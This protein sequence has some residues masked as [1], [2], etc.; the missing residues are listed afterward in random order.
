MKFL[1]IPLLILLGILWRFSTYESHLLP[2]LSSGFLTAEALVLDAPDRRQAEQRLRVEWEGRGLLLKI[3]PYLLVRV[4]DR[5]R[6]S[7]QILDIEA[8]EGE[9]FSYRHYLLML[10]IQNAFKVQYLEVEPMTL[11]ELFRT[12]WR[13]FLLR[14]LEDV[15]RGFEAYLKP[16]YVEPEWGLVSGLLL[17]SRAG[18]EPKLAAAFRDAGLMHLIAVSGYNIS[19]V[20]A[21]AISLLGFLSFRKRLVGSAC[22]VTLFVLL[23]GPSAS[24][25]RAALMGC[26]ALFAHFTG[27][28]SVALFSLLWGAL[29]IGL[30][31]PYRLVY[32]IGF[33]LSFLATLS[34]LIFH[35][36]L[37]QFAPRILPV[38]ERWPTFLQ[39]S[40]LLAFAAQVFTFP[41][42]A[43]YFQTFSWVT[44]P[45]NIAVAPFLPVAMALSGASILFPPI[46]LLNIGVLK[47]I[48][49]VALVSAALPFASFQFPLTLF[50]FWLFY[51]G[52]AFA[53]FLFYKPTLVRAFRL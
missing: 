26:L 45:A 21:A 23:V 33:Q 2:P 46:S 9:A 8:R 53:L 29:I 32:D 39:E 37:I 42:T 7:G 4:G 19:L 30:I 13:L 28:R 10:G 27:R 35:P 47:I 15:R 34:L 48:E 51:L 49:T 14:I 6:F 22:L 17:G 50:E 52:L 24:V 31:N 36:V 12:D 3:D 1:Y 16:W 41:I 43:Y 18:L 40:F 38:W 44:I 20:V 5:V 11:E 25:I